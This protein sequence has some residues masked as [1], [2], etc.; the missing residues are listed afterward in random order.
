MYLL[1]RDRGLP[2][3]PDALAK[4]FKIL[5]LCFLIGPVPNHSLAADDQTVPPPQVEMTFEGSGTQT[6]KLFTVEDGWKIDWET[7]SPT[8]KLL[9]HGSANRPYSAPQSER[10]KVLKFFET[11]Q[12]IVLANSTESKGQA[13][14]PHGGTFY[15][16]ILAK[17]P[18]T[19]RLIT[20]K[21]TKDYLDVPY[22]GAP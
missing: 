11:V 6:T 7:E 15:L 16:K 2:N 9:A 5:L 14:H 10:D 3:L 22:T 18:W 20:V 4:P 13:F 21:D 1:I 17:G 12:P 19:L 8:F